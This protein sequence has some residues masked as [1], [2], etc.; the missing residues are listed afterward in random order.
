MKTI[1]YYHKNSNIVAYQKEIYDD[2]YWFERTYDENGNILTF[3][4]SYGN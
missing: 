2:G 4:N 1:K 3:K